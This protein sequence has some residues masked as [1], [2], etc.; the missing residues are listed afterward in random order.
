MD[1]FAP[2]FQEQF[3]ARLRPHVGKK[4][5]ITGAEPLPDKASD[6]QGGING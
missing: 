1:A 4:L 5:Y 6:A 2:Y 3:L